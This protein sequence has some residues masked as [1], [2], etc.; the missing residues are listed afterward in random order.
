MR[1]QLSPRVVVYVTEFQA[2]ELEIVKAYP[3]S[4]VQD[5]GMKVRVLLVELLD[6]LPRPTLPKH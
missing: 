1:F 2:V 3:E 5:L 4:L 6:A